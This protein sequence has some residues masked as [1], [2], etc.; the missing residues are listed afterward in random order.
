[1]RQIGSD[2]G[3]VDDIVEGELVN[4]GAVLEEERQRLQRN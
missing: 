1:M 2:T 4:E 3:C